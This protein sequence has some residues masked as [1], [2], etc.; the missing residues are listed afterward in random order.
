MLNF[1]KKTKNSDSI[2]GFHTQLDDLRN[3]AVG[4]EIICDDCDMQ[5]LLGESNEEGKYHLINVRHVQQEGV[6]RAHNSMDATKL[7]HDCL[8]LTT[9]GFEYMLCCT[10]VA[11]LLFSMTPFSI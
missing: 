11:A 5:F 8:A 9:V 6:K 10:V 1:F 2:F 3:C 7:F 4:H